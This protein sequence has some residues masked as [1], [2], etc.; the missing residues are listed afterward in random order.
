MPKSSS[1]RQDAYHRV[2]QMLTTLQA[3]H[4]G[5]TAGVLNHNDI[6]GKPLLSA[7]QMPTQHVDVGKFFH[8]DVLTRY[9]NGETI[10][11]GKTRKIEFSCLSRS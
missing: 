3:V 9:W 4:G 5:K 2:D 8:F 11:N 6:D 7:S 10:P 1:L